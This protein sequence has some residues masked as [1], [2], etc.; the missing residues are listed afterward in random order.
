[1]L[2]QSSVVPLSAAELGDESVALAYSTRPVPFE[3]TVDDYVESLHTRNGFSRERMTAECAAEFDEAVRALVLPH[4]TN[5]VVE[6]DTLATVV[7]GL[8]SAASGDRRG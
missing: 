6:E 8:P 5:G 7:W 4:S 1:M 2:T 3:Q